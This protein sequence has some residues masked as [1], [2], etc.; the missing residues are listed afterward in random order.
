MT[1]RSKAR[2]HDASAMLL[3]SRI[4]AHHLV[5][6][7]AGAKRES[8]RA[9][10]RERE[11]ERERE[12]ARDRLVKANSNFKAETPRP[13]LSLSAFGQHSSL[14]LGFKICGRGPKSQLAWP[15]ANMLLEPA[16]QTHRLSICR[17]AVARERAK[18]KGTFTWAWTCSDCPSQT[19]ETL[20]K[21]VQSK[22]RAN[23]RDF[24]AAAEVWLNGAAPI[25]SK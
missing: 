12:E 3:C 14:S 7:Q 22:R 1:H 19:H 9:R 15:P 25:S 5:P 18:V 23:E 4:R 17:H 2:N 13:A 8:E 20:Q 21:T 6:A 11:R 24:Q 16:I 10:D